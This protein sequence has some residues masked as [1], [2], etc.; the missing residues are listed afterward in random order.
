MKKN[1]ICLL[2][3]AAFY[4]LLGFLLQGI[5]VNILFATSTSEGQNLQSIKISMN[6]ANVS[7]EQALQIIS[8][9][10][11]FNFSY[12]KK[13]VPL[14]EKLTIDVTDESLYDLL[15]GLASQYNLVFQR[16]NS[17]I[18][19]KKGNGVQEFSIPVQQ[20]GGGIKG[21]ITDSKTGEPL[22]GANIT[23]RG[24]N[25]GTTT[26]NQGYYSFDNLESGS[27]SMVIQYVGYSSKT[28]V[29]NVVSNRTVE[30]NISLSQALYDLN[31]V[32]VTGTMVGTEKRQL[33]T[34]ITIL[35]EKELQQLNPT[36]IQDIFQGQIPGVI[37]L[38]LGTDGQFNQKIMIRGANTGLSNLIE[39]TKILV[40]GVE[41]PTRFIADI[42]AKN[43]ERMEIIRGP[44]AS[45]L[46]G[47]EAA[48]G[49]IQ[50]FTKKGDV[51]QENVKYSFTVR[52]GIVESEY[53]SNTLWD[54]TIDGSISGGLIGGSYSIS[55]SYGKKD[56]YVPN[57]DQ[58]NS[59]I[60]FGFQKEMIR[61]FNVS[62]TARLTNRKFGYAGA[63]G[64]WYGLYLD[65]K[66]P[67]SNSYIPDP[68]NYYTVNGYTLGLNAS[69]KYSD[70]WEHNLNVGYN[71][72]RRDGFTVPSKLYAA[73]TLLGRSTND[74]NRP[75]FRYYT[76]IKLP[77]MDYFQVTILGGFEYV[78]PQWLSVG[79]N[80]RNTG[81]PYTAALS[82]TIWEENTIKRA[83]FGQAQ[84]GFFDKLFITTGIR[85]D[86]N[87]NNG[88]KYSKYTTNPRVGFSYLIEPVPGWIIKTRGSWGI[89]I[90]SPTLRMR[91]GGLPYALPNP[92]IGPQ[93][94]N[95]WEL[96]A[97][98]Y[99]FDGRLY[100]E[101]TY[102]YQNTED[103][104]SY[105]YPDP[106]NFPNQFKYLNLGEVKNSGLELLLRYTDQAINA[107][108]NIATNNNEIVNIPISLTSPGEVIGKPIGASP[109]PKL[110][111]NLSFSYNLNNLIG[112]SQDKNAVAGFEINYI[113][114]R[115]ANDRE[116]YFVDR[117]K[118]ITNRPTAYYL[119]WHEGFVKANFF[120]R[121]N[122]SKNIGLGLRIQN[123][124]NSF[125]QPTPTY[126]V[127][128]RQSYL[129]VFVDL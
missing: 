27:Y 63:A 3:M 73:D 97:D 69:Y 78:E 47:S 52:Q 124:L 58:T 51:N 24:T 8:D 17:Q 15:K 99:L 5:M 76:N 72:E 86:Y 22:L 110:T 43:I 48:G 54:R 111:A 59:N 109:V 11:K 33:G 28:E 65:G 123:L 46:Y 30:L 88:P 121:Y 98:Q 42:S 56:G 9:K 101:F 125:A 49:V 90:Q 120:A 67:K 96:G 83:F 21:R 84:F 34:S 61:N 53:L 66:L 92:E 106:V 105:D 112:L 68:N 29:I 64:V 75:T 16:I 95:G 57:S 122:F 126:D 85:T 18:V 118:G 129:E 77:Q 80:F 82:G 13:E 91:A 14:D 62:L 108:A 71:K 31:E 116:A 127:P 2:K 44:Q 39:P 55:G 79:T 87:S 104:I 4:T 10:T 38:D 81:E 1:I 6:V 40:D 45:T 107:S 50:I 128:G 36:S 12:D 35:K 23:L 37:S 103:Y 113:G 32:I 19:I 115:W 100:F 102:Y 20:A 7:F 60:S 41:V 119:R 25:K 117:S 74:Y 93:K 89:G 114:E 26:D 70:W 94:T